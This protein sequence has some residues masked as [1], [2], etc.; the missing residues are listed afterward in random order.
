MWESG[1]SKTSPSCSRSQAI[2]LTLIS[3]RHASMLTVNTLFHSSNSSWV[4]VAC[5]QRS[6]TWTKHSIYGTCAPFRSRGS[7]GRIS[8]KRRH[9]PYDTRCAPFKPLQEYTVRWRKTP[10]L[11]SYPPSRNIF[12]FN[13][14]R[15]DIYTCNFLQRLPLS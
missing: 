14:P 8:Q 12:F 2:F 6:F 1:F 3:R 13:S 4:S 5:H 11:G 15:K 7:L 9:S 10:E